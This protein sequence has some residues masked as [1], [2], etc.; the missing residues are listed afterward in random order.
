MRPH[1]TPNAMGVRSLGPTCSFRAAGQRWMSAASLL[2][3][4]KQKV[5][6][7]TQ[8]EL[9]EGGHEPG[10]SVTLLRALRL[11]QTPRSDLLACRVELRVSFVDADCAH[12]RTVKK[13]GVI[14]RPRMSNVR[15]MSVSMEVQHRLLQAKSSYIMLYRVN[16]RPAY[17]I[18]VLATRG[19][20]RIR[21]PSGLRFTSQ[22]R[23]S[24]RGWIFRLV[25][26]EG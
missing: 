21:A 13:P 26:I 5:A 8:S 22:R 6:I 20:R 1:G 15:S 2:A 10:S 11:A 9:T 16:S 12:S 14:C 17:A 19:E 4:V 18:S 25:Q 7:F 23:I 3:P 24:G